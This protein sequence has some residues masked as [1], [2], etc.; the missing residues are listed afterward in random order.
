MAI[1]M[2]VNALLGLKVMVVHHWQV[3]PLSLS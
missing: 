3:M 2:L 1:R